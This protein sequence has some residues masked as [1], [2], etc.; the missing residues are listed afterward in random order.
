MSD[1]S[2]DMFCN[3]HD[4]LLP[5]IQVVETIKIPAHEWPKINIE[6]KIFGLNPNLPQV[7]T[8]HFFTNKY[9]KD[10]GFDFAWRFLEIIRFI[11]KNRGNLLKEGLIKDAGNH[12][13]IRDELLQALLDS[14]ST[15]QSPAIFPE[16]SLESKSKEFSY[17]KVIK[18]TKS[19]FKK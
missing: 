9:G 13:E 17:R 7:D 5:I 19:Y 18:A 3:D 11:N 1:Y 6:G 15:V 14:F 12:T 8:V 16:S 10:K 4:Q 2:I